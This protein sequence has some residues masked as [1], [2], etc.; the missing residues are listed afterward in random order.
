MHL[1]IL[2]DL[3][4]IFGITIGVIIVCNFFKIPHLVG[5]LITGIIL[6][7][8]STDIL[9]QASEV[10]AFAEIGVILLLFTIGLEFSFSNLK[11]I[12]KYILLGGG[13]QVL[14]TIS[15]SAILILIMGRSYTES[16]FWGFVTALSSS[17]IVIKILQ[18]RN[19]ITSEHGKVIL[20][21]LLFQDIM[22]VPL[23]LFTPILAG[24][25]EGN[26]FMEIGLMLG[27]MVLLGLIAFVLARYLMPKFFYQIMKIKSQEVFLIATFFFVIVIT[28]IT[29]E[30]GFS[31]ALGAFLGGLIIA[32]TDY[33]RMA[34]SCI[35]PFRYVFISFFFISMGMLLDF[36]IFL[37]AY[38]LIAFWFA[39]IVLVK[40][41]AATLASRLLNVKFKTA[42]MVGLSIA[43][44]GEFSFVL[45]QSGLGYE[46]IAENSYQV[47]LAV[48]ILT[49]AITP[50]ALEYKSQVSNS[51]LKL[52]P[53]VKS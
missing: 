1:T 42:L 29:Y 14:L 9:N 17:A 22:I 13:L 21:M 47:F 51:M 49:M 3:A 20:A 23:M 53:H 12:K 48:S 25:V 27:K 36:R 18:D 11:K 40:I 43:Q 16:I 52:V 5:Y 32:E 37:T 33:N 10:E 31:L 4:I 26:V 34:I 15:I 44:I 24:Q 7:P 50:F 28:V 35:L 39:F 6:S 19:E 38:D 8:K 2:F 45:A 46:L 30:L 41:F